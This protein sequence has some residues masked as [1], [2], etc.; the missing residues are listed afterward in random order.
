MPFI[1]LNSLFVAAVQQGSL[2]SAAG[3]VFWKLHHWET[4]KL[5]E[6]QHKREEKQ[7]EEIA[8]AVSVAVSAAMNGL[9]LELLEKLSDDKEETRH[10]INGSFMR[11]S[12]VLARWD[13]LEKR[14][15]CLEK[16]R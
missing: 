3:A 6:K 12:E 11:S 16:D 5:I 7:R 14:V 15:R 8:T 9:K 13:G 4:T 1:D 2:L 10:W